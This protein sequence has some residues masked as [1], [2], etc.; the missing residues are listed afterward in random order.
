MDSSINSRALSLAIRAA[1]A[2]VA[3]DFTRSQR[4]GSL[5]R[6]GTRSVLLEGDAETVPLAELSASIAAFRFQERIQSVLWPNVFSVHQA[7][8]LTHDAGRLL[9]TRVPG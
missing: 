6:A 4:G 7:I 1:W 8:Q 3:V 9:P 2:A 5:A